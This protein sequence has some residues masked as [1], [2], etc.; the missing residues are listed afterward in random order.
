MLIIFFIGAISFHAFAQNFQSDYKKSDF[1]PYLRGNKARCEAGGVLFKSPYY[2]VVQLYKNFEI[3]NPKCNKITSKYSG[4]LKPERQKIKYMAQKLADKQECPEHARIS[5]KYL[6]GHDQTMQTLTSDKA[7][8]L[9]FVKKEAQKSEIQVEAS[10]LAWGYIM[11][12]SSHISTELRDRLE[13]IKDLEEIKY[14]IAPVKVTSNGQVIKDCHNVQ[15]SGTDDL[16]EFSIDIT[17]ATSGSGEVSYNTYSVPDHVMVETEDGEK[18]LDSSCLGTN[19]DVR[20]SIT[21]DKN[22]YK[23]IKFK[24]DALC[25]EENGG[26]TAWTI[27]FSCGPRNDDFLPEAEQK[28]RRMCKGLAAPVISS[29]KDNVELNLATQRHQWMRAICQKWNYGKVVNDYTKFNT[30]LNPQTSGEFKRLNLD[31]VGDFIA[32]EKELAF[33]D[34]HTKAFKEAP[35]SKARID[36]SMSK[37][38]SSPPT[39]EKLKENE[40]VDKQLEKE[41]AFIFSKD[42]K[43]KKEFKLKTFDE[44]K[45]NIYELLGQ[46]IPENESRELA[47]VPPVTRHE[48]TPFVYGYD[49]FIRRKNHYC[50][51]KPNV[52]E[53]LLKKVSYVY[54]HHAYP[55]LFGTEDDD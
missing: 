14:E 40:L 10:Y 36:I 38:K 55:R 49:D 33:K 6:T 19:H 12:S 7:R 39:K 18:L 5:K 47:S 42:P 1:N 50:P 16:E 32:P 54:C 23:T 35:K 21:L 29:L 48:V 37:K 28:R 46:T 41:L 20:K 53:S 51:E 30:L 3:E 8:L 2:N 45:R 43:R 11:C 4:D 9:D 15:A 26:S 31:V 22:K 24:V 13:Y 34:L 25:E 52:N 17:G 44:D 27:H